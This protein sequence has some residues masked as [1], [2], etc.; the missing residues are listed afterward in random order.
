MKKITF[1]IEKGFTL[2]EVLVVISILGIII[3]GVLTTLNPL[4]QIKKGND[5]KRKSDLSQ[6]QKALEAYYQDNGKYPASD[7]S[8]RI[9]D[10]TKGVIEWGTGDW[11]PYMQ[12]LLTDSNSTKKYAYISKDNNHQMYYLYASLDRGGLDPQACQYIIDACRTNPDSVN[13]LC[14]NAYDFIEGEAVI[15]D[16]GESM[17]CNYGVSSPNT[18]P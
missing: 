12:K 7:S 13:C 9:V 3:G 11:S 6:I 14:L 17:V 18:S 4:E 1:H 15:A 10:A 2:V 8:F 16:C 5:V